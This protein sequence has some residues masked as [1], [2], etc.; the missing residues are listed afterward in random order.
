MVFLF[1]YFF[2]CL[3]SLTCTILSH[4]FLPLFSLQS[5]FLFFF[6][7]YAILYRPGLHSFKIWFRD[8]CSTDLEESGNWKVYADISAAVFPNAVHC[9]QRTCLFAFPSFTRTLK[10]LPPCLDALTFAH[11]T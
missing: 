10:H 8:R 9:D 6:F 5:F 2:S 3:R 4:L 7:L 11:W 1:S